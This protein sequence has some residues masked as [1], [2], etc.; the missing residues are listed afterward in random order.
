MFELNNVCIDWL[1]INIPIIM[2]TYSKVEQRIKY[3]REFFVNY[4]EKKLNIG[5]DE[6]NF[7]LQNGSKFRQQGII[8][9]GQYMK[10]G[11]C[12]LDTK[13]ISLEEFNKWFK[14]DDSYYNNLEK[15]SDGC[16]D[17][18]Y[19]S[20]IFSG[21]GCREFEERFELTWSEWLDYLINGFNGW[22]TRI[23]LA[24]DLINYQGFKFSTIL[25]FTRRNWF[26]SS[27]KK[28]SKIYDDGEGQGIYFGVS[29]GSNCILFYNKLLERI[30]ANCDFSSSVE[31][32][33]RI[34]QRFYTNAK[35]L[36]ELL[37]KAPMFT[38]N[39]IYKGLLYGNLDFKKVSAKNKSSDRGD[40]LDKCDTIYWWKKFFTD[41]EKIQVKNQHRLESTISTTKKWLNKE[42]PVGVAKM[43]CVDDDLTKDFIDS[44]DLKIEGVKKLMESPKELSKVNN[45]RLLNNKK[46][47]EKNDLEVIIEK[48]EKIKSDFVSNLKG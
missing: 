10:F 31:S 5:D 45:E 24:C 47:L 3:A 1:S 38:Y 41:I 22:C 4:I 37:A 33:L 30:N 32:W 21:Q 28:V 25:D 19:M 48:L 36:G 44:Y 6:I 8:Y 43:C 40:N 11:V 39:S 27:F 26:T 29:R 2:P 12:S 7:E 13:R 15:N 23:D 14:R 46:R 18:Y 20:L 17:F 34:E 35:E 42:T 16:Y 9:F